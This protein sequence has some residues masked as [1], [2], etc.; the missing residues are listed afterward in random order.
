MKHLLKYSQFINESESNFKLKFIDKEPYI[1]TPS[2]FMRTGIPYQKGWIFKYK[3]DDYNIT[4]LS[5]KQTPNTFYRTVIS[6]FKNGGFLGTTAYDYGRKLYIE[7]DLNESEL[8]DVIQSR[9]QELKTDIL[10]QAANADINSLKLFINKNAEGFKAFIKHY[11]DSNEANNVGEA[12]IITIHDVYG[13]RSYQ[14]FE[15]LNIALTKGYV[16]TTMT[17]FMK[18]LGK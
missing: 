2:H 8:I 17:D 6:G 18:L 7:Q 11:L 9:E 15:I 16:F 3:F 5:D 4:K 12:F 10:K 1:V 14:T 13:E